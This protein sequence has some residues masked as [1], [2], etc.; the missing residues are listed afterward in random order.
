MGGIITSTSSAAE[1]AEA[2]KEFGVPY[3]PAATAILE[4]EAGSQE[5][6]LSDDFESL[7]NDLGITLKK[8]HTNRLKSEYD[9]FKATFGTVPGSRQA[10]E[11]SVTARID[12]LVVKLSEIEVTEELDT[13]EFYDVFISYRQNSDMEL[14]KSVYYRLGT[15][16]E[17]SIECKAFW[18]MECLKDGEPW[19]R[20]FVRGLMAS[21][22][23]MPIVSW[24][25]DSDKRKAGSVGQMDMSTGLGTIENDRKDNVLLEWELALV[26]HEWE[27]A[28]MTKIIP[29]FYGGKDE[30]SFKPLNFSIG[31]HL[32]N[33][34]SLVTKKYLVDIC[35]E[36]G[37][38]LSEA[39]VR[40]SVKDVFLE[41]S[42]CQGCMLAEFGKHIHAEKSLHDRLLK[43]VKEV[44]VNS[45]AAKGPSYITHSQGKRVK[46][47][48]LE[49]PEQVLDMDD[50]S[51][52]I[53]KVILSEAY[54]CINGTEGKVP[55][56]H[57]CLNGGIVPA[58]FPIWQI[59]DTPCG[60]CESCLRSSFRVLAG[61]DYLIKTAVYPHILAAYV[62]GLI[63]V[64]GCSCDMI[65][66]DVGCKQSG[67]EEVN[68]GEQLVYID[69][70]T[71]FGICGV[72][73]K[74]HKLDL[75]DKGKTWSYIT[76]SQ[77][78]RVKADDLEM[79]ESLLLDDGSRFVKTVLNEPYKCDNRRVDGAGPCLNGGIVPAGLPI[80][81][82]GDTQCGVC[83]SCL[84]SAYRK[85]CGD[86][87]LIKIAEHP[88]IL[89]GKYDGL[90]QLGG[91]TCD[92]TK[93]DGGCKQS[94]HEEV[95]LGEQL[96]YIDCATNFSICGVCASEY[97][98]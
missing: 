19:E 25:E 15:R 44:H 98:I 57:P 28:P 67:H 29:V 32:S 71:G 58:G 40:R 6:L 39:A 21:S 65:Y 24:H 66:T 95:N 89:F 68:L 75:H 38:P 79:P 96:V 42:K 56:L 22:I 13:D 72:C 52:K 20:G 55:G 34:P 64:G 86:N 94:G 48:K 53:V 47:D 10:E 11:R 17:D 43:A 61:E 33:E 31:E 1:I 18:D 85:L 97:Q 14:A 41:L 63:Q 90:I 78:K 35:K 82:I 69:C 23:M 54:A 87:Y 26:L 45:P 36:F 46:A 81:Q 30:Y 73:A 8:I 84:R 27:L 51:V 59:G 77:G 80:W 76:A 50:P 12:E 70:A 37:I 3:E 92:M 16:N 49:I 93:M 62:K 4:N 83:E 7:V 5:I 74:D 9:R 91:C 60:V 2:I 88:N